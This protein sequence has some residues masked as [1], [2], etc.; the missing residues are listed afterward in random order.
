MID[1]FWLHGI[2]MIVGYGVLCSL[3]SLYAIFFK[4][5]APKWRDMH[6]LIQFV[7]LLCSITGFRKRV[8]HFD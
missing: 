3:S 2:L 5:R 1:V 8:Y 7:A 6:A 4:Y